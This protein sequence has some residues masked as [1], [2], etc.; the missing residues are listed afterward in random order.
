MVSSWVEHVKDF[1]KKNG[2]TYKAAMVQAKDSY[3]KPV[4]GESKAH[5]ASEAKP[6]VKRKS[7]KEAEPKH[8]MPEVVVK[9][10]KREKLVVKHEKEQRVS[11][12]ESKGKKKKGLVMQ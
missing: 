3:T 9:S 7:K 1:Q 10:E 8:E 6:A 5:E 2:I 4:K 11:S 12:A